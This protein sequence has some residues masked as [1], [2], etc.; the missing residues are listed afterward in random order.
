MERPNS[1]FD[2]ASTERFFRRAAFRAS[3][4]S[5]RQF[6]ARGGLLALAVGAT[7]SYF[8]AQ[9]AL[10]QEGTPALAGASPAAVELPEITEVPV[11][12]KGSG[13]VFVT[14]SGGAYADAERAA[15]W[16]PFTRL[17]S[18]EVQPVEG[19]GTSQVKAQVD[20]G[21]VEWD[22]VS[23]DYSNVL[24]LLKQGDYFEPVDYSLVDV[25]NIDEAQRH[26][27]AMGHV[28]IGTVMN[29]RTDALGG[30]VPQSY[31]D[32]WDLEAFP[33]PRNWMSGA[34]G[35][36]PF[37]EGALLADGVPM[38]Q[39][40]PLDIKRALDSLSKIRDNIVKFWESGAQSAQLMAD[41]ETV[42]GVAWN[43]RIAAIE[44]DGAPV[45]IQWN[46]A[47]LQYDNW[48]V[49]KG[50]RNKE[51]AMKYIAFC[52]MPVPQAR[53][54]LLIPYGFVNRKAADLIPAS[55]L[56][57]LPTAPQHADKVFTSDSEWWADHLQEATGA[58][59]DWLLA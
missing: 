37:L 12:L 52:S 44:D 19:F 25:A 33:G 35:I 43:G 55:R 24:T 27:F 51:N 50:A 13:Q 36:S 46:Q 3:G 18:I 6:L 17:T 40:Y 23:F 49:L 14:S 28:A 20:S 22:V 7:G 39:L 59:N 42:L 45:A 29:Y 9:R 57:R 32:F 21:N 34:M 30:K 48:A 47:M 5:R 11:E 41:N 54:S 16:E 8:R 53:L 26:E 58:W 56:D 1:P 4:L 2:R 38:D 15:C 10:A 31:A